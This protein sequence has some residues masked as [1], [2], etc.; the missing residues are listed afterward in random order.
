MSVVSS[1]YPVFKGVHFEAITLSPDAVFGAVIPPGCKSVRLAANV[2]DTN[3]WV[4]LPALATVE[5]GH[6]VCI[7]AG[8]VTCEVRTPSGSNEKINGQDS[9]GTK[10]YNL[11]STQVHYFTKIDNTIGW[12]GHGYTAIGAK[13]TAIVPD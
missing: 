10:E 5:N 9:D 1:D 11:I 12:E 6:T 13:T 7:I 3:D 4:V 2:N 8:A